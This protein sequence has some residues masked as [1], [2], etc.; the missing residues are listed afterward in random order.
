MIARNSRRV[1]LLAALLA[2]APSAAHAEDAALIVAG[3]QKEARLNVASTAPGEG[4]PKFMQAFKAKYPFLDVDTGFYAAPTGRVLARVKAEIEA[5]NVTFDVVLAANLAAF[6]DMAQ[7]G[8]LMRYDS[9][10][11][12]ALPAGGK[13]PGLWGTA[14]VIGI[15]MAYN[16]NL[17]AAAD[18]PKAWA[19]L[20]APAFKGKKIAIQNAAA[21]T[22]FN[23][24]YE[25]ERVLGLD[26]LKRLG[27]Q[28]LVIMATSA[29]VSD[30]I[31]RGEVMVGAT[32][33]HW[34]AFE[35]DAIKA[36]IAP[37]YP[38]EGMPVALAPVAILAG[39][40]HP[41]AAKLFIDFI[42]S[43]EGQTLLDSQLYGMYS[44]RADVPAPAGQRPLAETHP[45]LPADLAD[46]EKASAEFPQHFEALFK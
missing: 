43:K 36:G 27:R 28:E 16:R 12:A 17:L 11:Y 13:A 42:L 35:P 18:V 30:A 10:E 8:E 38:A 14:Q 6:A 9:P 31:I 19:D 32:V 34:R 37:V 41:N 4:F 23:Q 1:A 46:Y 3:A 39:A 33:D 7:K 40:T 26:Y 20:L 15:I 29:Q 5:R 25:L 21:G 44:L 45:L 22:A 24:F 2:L